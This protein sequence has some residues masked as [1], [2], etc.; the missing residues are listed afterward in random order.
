[1]R[2]PGPIINGENLA[3]NYFDSLILRVVPG[4][5]NWYRNHFPV[6]FEGNCNYFLAEGIYNKMNAPESLFPTIEYGSAI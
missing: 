2:M 1:M 3:K 6:I 4:S 5:D